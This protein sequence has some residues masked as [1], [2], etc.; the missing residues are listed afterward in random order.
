MIVLEGIV[1]ANGLIR[2]TSE[3]R[4]PPQTKVYILV[5]NTPQEGDKSQSPYIFSPRLAH[6]ERITHY[7]ME[8]IEEPTD[9][10][11]D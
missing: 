11:S 4:L 3:T 9:A 1:E 7:V 6:S 2:V 10:R 5:P 8:L